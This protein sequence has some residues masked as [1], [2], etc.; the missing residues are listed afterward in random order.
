[1]HH[2]AISPS[3]RPTLAPAFVR[4]THPA[5]KQNGAPLHTLVYYK[6]FQYC[7]HPIAHLTNSCGMRA[8]SIL[9][10]ELPLSRASLWAQGGPSNAGSRTCELGLRTA[11]A[12]TFRAYGHALAQPVRMAAFSLRRM[13]YDY[14]A[15][16]HG[17]YRHYW[18]CRTCWWLR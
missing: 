9:F 15:W 3:R 16:G 6:L 1:M 7:K 8:A 13:E 4:S 5:R 12:L 18:H 2:A 14:L 11:L 17:R 10:H